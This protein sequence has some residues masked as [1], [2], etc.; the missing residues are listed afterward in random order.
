MPAVSETN[1]QL[2][3]RYSY[4]AFEFTAHKTYETCE[5]SSLAGPQNVFKTQRPRNTRTG[6]PLRVTQRPKL[7]LPDQVIANRYVMM[8]MQR[9]GSGHNA[10]RAPRTQH[11]PLPRGHCP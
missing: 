7:T 1:R 8:V 6:H 3:S 10:F 4:N 9:L 11:Q 2:T 5:D